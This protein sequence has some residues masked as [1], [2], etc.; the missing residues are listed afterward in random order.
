MEPLYDRL[1]QQKFESSEEAID[2]CRKSC[3]EYGFNI[4]YETGANKVKK[5]FPASGGKK[6]EGSFY[7]PFYIHRMFISTVRVKINLL[8]HHQ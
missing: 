3:L 8:L 2:Y 1:I 5:G 4:K 6:G 7:S